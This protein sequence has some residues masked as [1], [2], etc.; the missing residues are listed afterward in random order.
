MGSPE[1]TIHF[2]PHI[3]NPFGFT[4]SKVHVGT[5]T[6]FCKAQRYQTIMQNTGKKIVFAIGDNKVADL[7]SLNKVDA[8]TKQDRALYGVVANW[9]DGSLE[10]MHQGL[11]KAFNLIRNIAGGSI[12]HVR[13]PE[14]YEYV[15]LDVAPG[16]PAKASPS[17]DPVIPSI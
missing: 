15:E 17:K 14:K 1:E 5:R 16:L 12:T 11:T 3:V 7:G 4:V 13:Y 8:A 6:S 2:V 9:H 10:Q